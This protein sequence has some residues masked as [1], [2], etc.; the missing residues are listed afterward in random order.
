MKLRNF[1]K[2]DV[3]QISKLYF[4]TVREVNS[5]DYSKKQVETWASEIYPD[6]FWLK[7][8]DNYS[9]K[10][11]EQDD[12]IIGFFEYQYT[13]HIDCFYVHHEFQRK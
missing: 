2:Q 6:E 1:K 13:G 8:F 10:V 12:Q 7:R 4:N 9:V 11:V 3:T 5:K